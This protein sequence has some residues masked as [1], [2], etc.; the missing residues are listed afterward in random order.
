M[1]ILY[2]I[3][4]GVV[5]EGLACFCIYM[6]KNIIIVWHITLCKK[7][8]GI[9]WLQIWG[10]RTIVI[11]IY[12]FERHSTYLA[13]WD[14]STTAL[15]SEVRHRTE[16][17][18]S[19]TDPPI[20]FVPKYIRMFLHPKYLCPVGTIY[21]ERVFMTTDRLYGLLKSCFSNTCAYA[22]IYMWH[23]LW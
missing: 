1:R 21:T 8:L 3:L 5:R 12:V 18:S 20:N 4:E 15:N 17:P 14:K 16:S 19:P 11:M 2:D 10:L 22:F 7:Q 23:S 6:T 13:N 9:L